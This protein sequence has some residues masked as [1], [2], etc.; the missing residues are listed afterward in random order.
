MLCI[1]LCRAMELD[2]SQEETLTTICTFI[3]FTLLNASHEKKG[4]AMALGTSNSIWHIYIYIYI[5]ISFLIF[6]VWLK[7]TTYTIIHT[8][9]YKFIHTYIHTYTQLIVCTLAPLTP[10]ELLPLVV[11]KSFVRTILAARVNKKNILH[12]MALEAIDRIVEGK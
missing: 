10:P 9:D 6:V 8:N 4:V 12:T 5:Y 2:T 3:D 1:C 11:S 7:S